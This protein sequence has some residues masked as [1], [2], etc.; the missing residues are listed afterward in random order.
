MSK[1][2][3]RIVLGSSARIYL[4]QPL[5]LALLFL[6]V[7]N[8]VGGYSLIARI[9]SMVWVELLFLVYLVLY[10]LMRFFLAFTSA[11]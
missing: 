3:A 11:Y 1:N 4:P 9:G 8:L 6:L 10:S 7:A 5:G 2:C